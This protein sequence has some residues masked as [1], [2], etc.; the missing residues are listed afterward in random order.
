MTHD[1]AEGGSFPMKQ[2][3]MSNM[4]GVTRPSVN[5]AVNTLQKAGLIRHRK[6]QLEVL[7]REGLEDAAC[8]CYRVVRDRYARLEDGR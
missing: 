4:L 8:E 7:D 3:F 6:G 2:E 5:V 1:R